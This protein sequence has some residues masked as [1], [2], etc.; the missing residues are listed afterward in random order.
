MKKQLL[1]VLIVLN[2]SCS[3]IVD[4]KNN[5]DLIKIVGNIELK[6][7]S[8]TIPRLIKNINAI[9]K[10]NIFYISFYNKYNSAVYVYNTGTGEILKKIN[11]TA[12]GCIKPYQV[13]I[14]NFDTIYVREGKNKFHLLSY[15]GKLLKTFDIERDRKKVNMPPFI[16]FL[17]SSTPINFGNKLYLSGFVSD[18]VPEYYN[19][20]NDRPSVIS[21][22]KAG[23]IEYFVPIPEEYLADN[24][25]YS[26][27]VSHTYNPNRKEMVLCFQAVSCLKSFNLET[28]QIKRYNFKS[29]FFAKINPV[30]NDKNY[31]SINDFNKQTITQASIRNVIFDQYKHIYYVLIQLPNANYNADNI[32]QG[33]REKEW[34]ILVLNEEFEKLTEKKIGNGYQYLLHISFVT[35]IGLHVL[36]VDEN[37]NVAKFDIFSI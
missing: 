37:E 12:N 28:Y 33:I 10:N 31:F 1:I 6:L 34:S 8:V 3:T 25:G 20:I 26:M 11:I 36:K 17:Y 14:S 32:K 15:S 27:D 7:D 30:C 9:E 21:L 4:K 29:D 23:D 24:Y 18:N 19:V 22:S 16:S 35:N 5:S 13:Q 2:I